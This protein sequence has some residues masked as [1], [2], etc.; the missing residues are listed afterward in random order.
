MLLYCANL[1]FRSGADGEVS[2]LT[3]LTE[4]VFHRSLTVTRR[5]HQTGESV[6]G[7]LSLQSDPSLLIMRDSYK[8]NS[9]KASENLQL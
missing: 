6:A 4:M 5:S 2:L 9:H 1:D 7:R 8:N 3:G